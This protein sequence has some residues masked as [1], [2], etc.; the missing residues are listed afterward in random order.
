MNSMAECVNLAKIIKKNKK[1]GP[2]DD[3]SFRNNFR[4]RSS[5]ECVLLPKVVRFY[6]NKN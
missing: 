3:K 6:I 4:C 2:T 1:I 5:S